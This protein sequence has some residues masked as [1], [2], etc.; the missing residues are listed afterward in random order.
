MTEPSHLRLT[1]N[2]FTT[3]DDIFGLL[4][5][6][7][8]KRKVTHW[9]NISLW[10]TYH[11][12]LQGVI[13]CTILQNRH[14]ANLTRRTGIKK[15]ICLRTLSRH[16]IAFPSLNHCLWIYQRSNYLPVYCGSDISVLLIAIYSFIV[17][18]ICT[19]KHLS[20][21]NP[22]IL[23]VFMLF[24]LSYSI[25]VEMVQGK[26]KRWLRINSYPSSPSTTSTP[27][28]AASSATPLPCRRSHWSMMETDKL[29]QGAIAEHT[30]F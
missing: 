26:L 10:Q 3:K 23:F 25:P 4:F 30:R 1:S 22:G 28:S 16:C 18:W 27:A 6:G 5:W 24:A 17:K 7:N 12:G 21:R 19:P 20:R 2:D 13:E 8:Q 29:F 9:T 14:M 11:R 15:L